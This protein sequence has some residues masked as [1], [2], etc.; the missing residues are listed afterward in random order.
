MIAHQASSGDELL[1]MA[2]AVEDTAMAQD[3][4]GPAGAADR[5]QPALVVSIVAALEA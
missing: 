3:Q 5:Q 2:R 4:V 1:A